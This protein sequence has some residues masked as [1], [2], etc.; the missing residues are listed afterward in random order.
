M[1]SVS[2]SKRRT[3][4]GK[5]GTTSLEFAL[6]LASFLWLLLGTIDI[7]RYLYT[8]QALIGLMGEAGRVALM[9]TTWAPQSTGTAA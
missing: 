2:N 5:L 4:L 7:A 1:S 3:W 9:D 8:V 6:V